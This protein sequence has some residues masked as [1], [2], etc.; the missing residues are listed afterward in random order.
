MTNRVAVLAGLG[1]VV[2]LSLTGCHGTSTEAQPGA[3]RKPIPVRTSKVGRIKIQRQVD[4]AGTLISPGQARVSSEVGGV[5]REVMVELGQDVKP[6]QTLVRLEPQELAF[7]LKR[8][9]SLLRQTEAQ[10]EVDGVNVKEPPP[11]EVIAAVRLALANRDD[12][13]AQLARAQR[14]STQGLLPE[15]DLDTALTRVKVTEAAYQSAL[16]TVRSLKA[17]LLD[18]RAAYELAQK[19]LDDSNIRAPVGGQIS[20]RLVQP[21]EYIRENTPVVTVVQMQPLKLRTAVQERHAA[22]IHPGLIV[23]FQAEPYP[24]F[25]FEGKIAFVSPAV[26]QGTRTFAIEALVDNSNRRLKP[27][28]FAKGVIFTREDSDVL[29]VP[30]DAI[31]TLAGVSTVFIVDQGKARQQ[32]IVLGARKDKLVEV[33]EGLKGAEVLATTNL[34]QLATGVPVELDSSKP[35]GQ[36]Q[37]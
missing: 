28:F 1:L 33:V 18:R 17:S 6:G 35:R 13:R 12:A 23:Q 9:E 5:V 27:G 3:Q 7:A 14:L 16:D 21:G 11:D 15:Q 34:S 30:E 25:V 19:K 4:V 29:A 24:D 10:L 20:E 36:E 26:E 2:V 37:P 31:S 8:A 32:I 22:L